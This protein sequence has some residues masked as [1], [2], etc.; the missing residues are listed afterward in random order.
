MFLE[1]VLAHNIGY[2]FEVD[3]V[4]ASC[5][6]SVVYHEARGEPLEG[7]VAVAQ[8]LMN[9]ATSLK[10]TP[11]K[12]AM[13]EAQFSF[14]YIPYQKRREAF[15]V[16]KKP[17]KDAQVLATQIALQ[18]MVGGFTGHIHGAE[19]FYNPYIVVPPPKWSYKFKSKKLINNHLFLW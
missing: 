17:D 2:D 14:T 18:A 1:L 7:Q 16:A 4:Q 3:L 13:R 6:A 11:C 15:L 5:V 19:H 9:R 12:E 8:V 10:S